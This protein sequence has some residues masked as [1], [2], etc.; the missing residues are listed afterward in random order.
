MTLP[1]ILLIYALC[2][3]SFNVTAVGLRQA[4]IC[5]DS[6]VEVCL[7]LNKVD[8]ILGISSIQN[9]VIKSNLNT[10]HITYFKVDPIS[11]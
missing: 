11:Y 7:T 8:W 2:Q 1:N 3:N 5:P 9:N 4:W 6:D 10:L